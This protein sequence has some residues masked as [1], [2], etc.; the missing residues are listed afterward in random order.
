MGK[1]IFIIE[2]SPELLESLEETLRKEGFEVFSQDT[3][4]DALDKIKAA[5]PDLVVLDAVLP[6]LDGNAIAAQL[7]ADDAVKNIPIIVLSHL[8]QAKPLFEKFGQVKGF[9]ARPVKTSELLETVKT[10]LT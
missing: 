2:D 3:G 7:S 1:K 10:A 6:V 8:M 9:L 4:R 5:A